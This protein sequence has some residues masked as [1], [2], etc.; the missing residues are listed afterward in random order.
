MKISDWKIALQ[1]LLKNRTFSVVSILGLAVGFVGFMVVTLYIRHEFNWDKSHHNY[2][3]IYRVQ[4]YYSRVAFA[5][6]GSD[7]SPH[8][9]SITASLLEVF[10]EFE[11]V[12]A[13]REEGGKYL[14]KTIENQVYDNTGIVADHN[15]LDVFTYQFIE[16]DQRN[17]LTEPFSILLSRSMAEKLFGDEKALGQIVMYEKK[18]DFK[19]TGVYE[20]LPKNSTVHPSYILSFSTLKNT[21]NIV[22]DESWAGNFMTYALLKPGV[23]LADTE[24]KIKHVYAEFEG[25]EFEELQLCPLSKVYLSFN[26]QKDYYIMLAIFGIIGLFIL[27]MSAFNYVNY[28]IA[29]ASKRGKEVAIRKISGAEKFSLITQLQSE[30]LFLTITASDGKQLHVRQ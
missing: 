18:L 7:I 22:R 16:G 29:T 14:S 28:T 10:P 8:S 15:F 4:R 11:K 27:T 12:T 17:S 26:G 21:E 9:H 25:R 30:T 19:V 23:N 20:E 2:D 5:Q 6:D 1:N 3:H 13:I 24:I